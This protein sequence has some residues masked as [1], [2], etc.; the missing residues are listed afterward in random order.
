MEDSSHVESQELQDCIQFLKEECVQVPHLS[1]RLLVD[2]VNGLDVVDDQLRFK[3]SQG[4][5]S[6]LTGKLDG[7]SR[8]REIIIQ[9]TQQKTMRGLLSWVEELTYN[10]SITCKALTDTRL[11]LEKTRG[12]LMVVAQH[13]ICNRQIIDEHTERIVRI[14][15]RLNGEIELRLQHLEIDNE[16]SRKCA[17]WQAGS[18]YNDY[19][20]VIQAVFVVDD[21][22]RDTRGHC[23]SD[24]HSDYLGDC[25]VSVMRSLGFDPNKPV[26][27]DDWLRGATVE[28]DDKKEVAVWLLCNRSD[29][30]L[31]CAIGQSAEMRAAVPWALD[32]RYHGRL[33]PDYKP[34]AMVRGLRREAEKALEN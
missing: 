13:S 5:L 10:T 8:R 3:N 34:A 6:R 31:H 16:I 9:Q 11:R 30:L 32:E 29:A 15:Q 23:I 17:A 19:P 1:E 28:N 22:M 27:L 18:L 24:A 2:T 25:I 12:D 7:S 21:L 33:L 14:E 26:S 20:T 4:L